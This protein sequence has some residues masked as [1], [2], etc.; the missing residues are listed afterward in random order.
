MRD[1]V[2]CTRG[3]FSALQVGRR[4]AVR[5]E[6]DLL[7]DLVSGAGKLLGQGVGPH[8]CRRRLEHIDGAGLADLARVMELDGEMFVALVVL[9]VLAEGEGSGVVA[10]YL[11]RR[12]R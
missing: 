8:E 11:R 7:V 12:Q 1:L 3:D 5:A 2:H 10:K 9:W 4:V 6:Q